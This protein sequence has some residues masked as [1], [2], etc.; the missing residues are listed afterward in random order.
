VG[1]LSRL[2]EKQTPRDLSRLVD[3]VQAIQASRQACIGQRRDGRV[4]EVLVV[5]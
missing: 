2:L 1:G 5:D 3:L 4:D